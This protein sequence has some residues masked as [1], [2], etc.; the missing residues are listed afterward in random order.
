MTLAHNAIMGPEA[1]LREP[2]VQRILMR[3]LD[4]LDAQPAIERTNPIR[5][6]LDP[7]MAPEIH[8]A[9]S[10][11]SRAVAWASIDG[12]VAAEWA[13]LDYRKHRKQGSREE[14]GPY[15][16]FQWSTELESLMRQNLGRQRKATSYALQW[17]ALLAQAAL[18]LSEDAVAKLGGMPIEISGRAIEEVFSRFLS[19][20]DLAQQSFLLREVSS[21]VFWGLSKVLDGRAGAVA[22]LLNCDECP[23]PEQPIVLNVHVTT[24]PKAFLFIENYVAFER[25][26][27]R[28]DLSDMALV[29]S[30]GFRGA[31][32]RLR[33]VGGCSVYYS[34]QSAPEAMV[35]FEQILMSE[36]DIP[37]FFW[38]DLDYSGMAILVSLRT[39]FP[40]AQAWQQGYHPMLA[41][42]VNGDG[43]SP[44]ESGKERQRVIEATGCQYADN[45]LLPALKVHRKFLDQE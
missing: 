1:A 42:L 2:L 11:A 18:P 23:F 6:N 12:V 39:T 9:D 41:R 27:N 29:F 30:S 4:R 24:E 38:G 14:R 25:L 28:N 7:E 8:G 10:L 17:A 34:R 22:A 5:I 15:L 20:R 44:I 36:A 45:Y 37:T 33:A 32:A 16:D 13:S 26:K 3:V 43:H 19:I 31:A 40:S 21:R 35:I